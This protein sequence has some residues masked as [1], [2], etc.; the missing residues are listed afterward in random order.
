MYIKKIYFLLLL[1]SCSIFILNIFLPE[2]INKKVSKPTIRNNVGGQINDSIE[3]TCDYINPIQ[4]NKS[5]ISA[6]EIE[7]EIP[8]S[9]RWSTNL[10]KARLDPTPDKYILDK[11][12]KKFN[13][14]VSIK[15]SNNENCKLP[16]RIRLSGDGMEHIELRGKDIVSS[17]DVKLKKGSIN[18]IV[19]FKLFLPETRNGSSEVITAL[20]LKKLGYLSPR[21]RLIKAKVNGKKLQMILQE[22]HSKEM[23]ESNKLRESAII[24]AN[25]SLIFK[26]RS[27][28]RLG[29]L[30][31]I[32]FPRVINQRWLNKGSVNK[33][34]SLRGMQIHSIANAESWN[35]SENFETSFSDFLLSNGNFENEKRLSKYRALLIAMKSEHA[36]LNHNRRFY[37]DSFNNILIPIYYDGDSKLGMPRSRNWINPRFLRTYKSFRELNIDEINEAIKELNN[38]NVESFHEELNISGVKVD[39]QEVLS[40]KKDIASNLE[41]IKKYVGEERLLKWGVDPLDRYIDSSVKYGIAFS[42]D[43]INFQLCNIE[44]SQCKFKSLDDSESIQLLRGLYNHNNL[45]YYYAGSKYDDYLKGKTK[46]NYPKK[47]TNQSFGLINMRSSG[48][49][50]VDINEKK[51]I[52]S[53]KINNTADKVTIF[54]SIL[55]NW[56]INVDAKD[57]I[58]LESMQLLKKSILENAIR[59][60]DN[61]LTGLLT[62]QDSSFKRG[63]III[64]GG[65]LEDSLNIV[66]SIGTIDLISV[67]NS[68]QDAIDFDFSD[69][70][71][72]EVNVYK[73]GNDCLDLS[74]GT[75]LIK[76]LYANICYDKAVSVGEGAEVEFKEVKIKN[77]NMGLVSKDSSDLRIVKGDIAN[78]K[79]CV[80]AYRKKQ[81]FS[82]SKISIPI[83]L[84]PDKKSYIQTNSILFEK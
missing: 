58:N 5:I 41:E 37:F 76:K 10:I 55:N 36:L 11:Y 34:I 74:S 53:I 42:S 44:S 27:Q 66:R 22:K 65:E 61:L 75:Y 17:I 4:I 54:N 43:G 16:A 72:E 83:G 51:K 71:I 25:E 14:Y 68:Y 24:G 64:N 15:N 33:N 8:D 59:I 84:C 32:I 62:I 3:P 73:A 19:R 21:T 18:G 82:G 39:Y 52:I 63:K 9:R 29:Y 23:L 60:D 30:S 20:L 38:I 13:A 12:K 26:M 7:L 46:T 81:E 6:K 1:T 47:T 67:S 49:P 57:S 45:I 31:S 2:N 40:I 50:N 48:E 56:T 28:S 70:E 35:R 79:I 69:L 77:T 78:Y 80:A